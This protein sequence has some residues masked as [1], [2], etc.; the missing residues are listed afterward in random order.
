MKKLFQPGPVVRISTGVVSLVLALILI[1][2]AALGLLPNPRRVAAEQR[3][4]EVSL[5]G[6][7][8][9]LALAAGRTEEVQQLI[10][11]LIAVNP[12]L[13]SIGVRPADGTLVAASAGHQQ[14]WKSLP[15]GDTLPTHVVLQVSADDQRWGEIELLYKPG[16]DSFLRQ[17][18]REPSLA[19]ALL[20]GTLGLL[21]VYLYL[22]RALYQ[23]NPSNAVP[24]HVRNAFATLAEAVLILDRKG[25]VMLANA[26]FL[27]M[28]G[29]Q[30]EQLEGKPLERLPWLCEPVERAVGPLTMWDSALR[31][32]EAAETREIEVE[33]P[34]GNAVRLQLNCSAIHD[35]SHVA[36]GYLLSFNDVTELSTAN[37]RLRQALRELEASRDQI[38]RQN[39]ELQKH[40]HH[41]HLTGCLN[42]RAFFE[43][44][45]PLFAQA[46][47][48]RLAFS[49]IMVDIDHFKSFNDTYGHAVGDLVI[50]QVARTLTRGLRLDDILCRFGGE[51]FCIVLPHTGQVDGLPVAER[52]R[53]LI[54]NECGPG[55]RSVEGLRITASLGFASLDALPEVDTLQDLIERADQGL[56]AA[57]R[58]GRNRV[59]DG[60]LV[61]EPVESA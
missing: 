47:A 41:D 7:Q 46:V 54:E 3:T 48:G 16:T 39:A 33:L 19:L 20:L 50:Q 56:Y 22:K 57:K 5:I 40:A 21:S 2:D 10:D 18:L 27:R 1:A 15:D 24:Q 61:G 42:R 51:E 28:S 35:G 59:G 45:E 23:L 37:S 6:A 30:A 4:Q 31:E 11:A 58:G 34:G 25:R 55:V 17:L 43:R 12:S 49:C 60:A 36:R 44:A 32:N 29:T 53:L 8:L 9:N 38:E 13:Q 26:T 14:A 52:L